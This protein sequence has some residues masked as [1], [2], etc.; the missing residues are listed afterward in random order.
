MK[1]ETAL[2][3]LSRVAELQQVEHRLD[4]GEEPVV[5]LARECDVAA[6]ER[7]DRL[8]GVA[9]ELV[10]GGDAVLRRVLAVVVLVVERGSVPLVV[11][12]HEPFAE[13]RAAP[14]PVVDPGHRVGLCQ[15]LR[16]VV[17]LVDHPEVRL[18]DR[19]RVLELRSEAELIRIRRTA[20]GDVAAG[21]DM[22]R[23]EHVVVEVELVGSDAG[24]LERM[25]AERGDERLASVLLLDERVHVGRI[26]GIVQGN[27]RRV[28]VA[29]RARRRGSREQE[30][31]RRQRR[32]RAIQQFSHVHFS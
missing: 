13:L 5:A 9:I 12:R 28:H 18:Q 11:R 15:V 22:N 6:V 27:E 26:R 1:V 4:V 20:C 32:Q 14:G 19:L 7:R 8:P 21:G 2:R 30:S 16:R 24:L 17:D 3:I 25:D 23:V 29:R 31:S 10:V